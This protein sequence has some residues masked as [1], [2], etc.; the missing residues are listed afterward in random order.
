M[1]RTLWRAALGSLVTAV[2]ASPVTAQEARSREITLYGDAKGTL[3]LNETFRVNDPNSPV[4]IS[5]VSVVHTPSETA[6]VAEAYYDQLFRYL[7][8]SQK[9]TLRQYRREN[10]QI[11]I[12]ARGTDAVAVKFG[13]IVYDSFNEYLGGLTAITMDPPTTLM[14][15]SYTPPY[16]FKFRKYGVLGVYVR[17]ARL[18]DGTIWNANLDF[19]SREFTARRGE[20]TREQLQAEEVR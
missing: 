13:V 20:I 7:S 10:L 11:E 4:Q 18:A 1:K 12:S 15:W 8:D 2:L 16:L 14:E 9:E 5:R 17:Q 3:Y 6:A 19:I